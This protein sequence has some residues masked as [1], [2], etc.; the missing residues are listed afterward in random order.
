MMLQLAVF[1]SLHVFT[2]A[3]LSNKPSFCHDLDCPNYSV[4]NTFN[5][6]MNRGRIQCKTVEFSD[7]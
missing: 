3:T 1:A 5:V 2:I 7:I 6:S 4:L